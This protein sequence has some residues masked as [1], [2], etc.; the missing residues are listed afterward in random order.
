MLRNLA[1]QGVSG[2]QFSC[3]LAVTGASGDISGLVLDGT[4]PLRAQEIRPP[5]YYMRGPE[6]VFLCCVSLRILWCVV[7]WCVVRWC[8]CAVRSGVLRFAVL[9]P[10]PFQADE[11][12]SLI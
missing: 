5:I 1:V 9:K 2:A 10:S 3:C 6:Y 4:L 11:A 7:C 8:I 12:R